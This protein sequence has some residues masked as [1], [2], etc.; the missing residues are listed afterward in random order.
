MDEHVKPGY[1]IGRE[2][3]GTTAREREVM[4]LLTSG[5]SVT[6]TGKVTGLSRQRVHQLAM[7]LVQKGLLKKEGVKYVAVAAD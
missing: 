3:D 5:H 4:T 1:E 6:A 7:S 2:G